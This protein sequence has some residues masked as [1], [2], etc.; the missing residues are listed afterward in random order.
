MRSDICVHIVLFV[1]HFVRNAVVDFL[2]GGVIAMWIFCG[3]LTMILDSS[4][5]AW[6]VTLFV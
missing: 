3:G 4:L 5:P 1:H 2:L 6:I